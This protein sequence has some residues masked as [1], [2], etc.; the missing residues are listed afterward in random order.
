[1]SDHT[2]TY[3]FA[4]RQEGGVARPL[5]PAGR[6][7]ER[8]GRLLALVSV[9]GARQPLV[10]LAFLA[11]GAIVAFAPIGGRPLV[12]W[13]APL[14]ARLCGR[15]G[16]TA[17]LSEHSL[18]RGRGVRPAS[19]SA[20]IRWHLSGMGRL[21]IR[22]VPTPLGEVAVADLSGGRRSASVT[23]A[24]SGPRFGLV[25]AEEQA[26]A[27]GSWGQLLGALARESRELQRLQLTERIVPDDLAPH[28]AYLA[29][30][31]DG[32]EPGA[33]ATYRRE[34]ELLAGTAVRH[35]VL[36][37]AT[38]GKSGRSGHADVVA[39]ECVRLTNL[40]DSAGFLARPLD[41][42]ALASTIRSIL[43]PEG[44]VVLGE[45]TAVARAAGMASLVG[46]LRHG[47]RTPRELRSVRA[48][49]PPGRTGVGLAARPR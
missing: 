28:F 48:A 19:V 47:L 7:R 32:A 20:P 25:D 26:R 34:L 49:T 40:L 12:A 41:T 36:L 37:T 29:E 8:R 3:R 42:V 21:V 15:R 14:A 2:S 6:H 4:P 23:F 18:R 10:G 35:E 24:L 5:P 11:L 9:L 43:D 45:D 31:A 38:L 17:P 46:H 1:M 16:A 44:A 22:P 39:S 27:L 30:V 13:W 33:L